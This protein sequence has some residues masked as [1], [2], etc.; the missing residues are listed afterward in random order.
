MELNDAADYLVVAT[1]PARPY[2]AL[3]APPRPR[4]CYISIISLNAFETVT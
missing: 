1:H 2:C 4:L 3:A